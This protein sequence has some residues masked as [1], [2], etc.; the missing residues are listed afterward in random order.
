MRGAELKAAQEQRLAQ[1]STG[2]HQQ[3]GNLLS[4]AFLLPFS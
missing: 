1:P 4:S 3:L 2:Q